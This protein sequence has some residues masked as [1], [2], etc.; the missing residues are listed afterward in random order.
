MN[1]NRK[2]QYVTV[3]CVILFNSFAFAS[4]QDNT[5]AEAVPD[6]GIIVPEK[7]AAELRAMVAADARR[8]ALEAS[9]TSSTSTPDK[10]LSARERALFE[11]RKRAMETARARTTAKAEADLLSNTSVLVEADLIGV[12]IEGLQ[13]SGIK[14]RSIDHKS[15]SVSNLLWCLSQPDTATVISQM[16]VTSRNNALSEVQSSK[17]IFDSATKEYRNAVKRFSAKTILEIRD[18][19][20]VDV[21][22]QFEK[23]LDFKNVSDFSWQGQMNVKSGVPQIAAAMQGFDFIGEDHVDKIITFLVITAT[24][25]DQPAHE[26]EKKSKKVSELSRLQGTWKGKEI[27][28]NRGE[29]TL[30]IS[31]HKIQADGPGPEDYTGEI[32]TDETTSPKSA[33]YYIKKCAFKEF[34]GTVANNIYK[35][36]GDKLLIA[37]TKPG[38]GTKPTSFDRDTKTE[39]RV[40]EFT[41]V[42]LK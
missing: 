1:A 30:V 34:E 37:G 13:K 25:E 6:S 38:S 31:G 16:K 11:A 33:R 19:I 21:R 28:V 14:S 36:D 40:F 7:L 15:V 23:L 26:T 27:G 29:W 39:T 17:A 20:S 12:T 22:Y 18:N 2:W 4:Q 35:F 10:S 24:I 42:K 5:G 3:I 9:R 41:K 8:G 32:I